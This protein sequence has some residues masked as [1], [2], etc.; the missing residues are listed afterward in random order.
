MRKERWTRETGYGGMNIKLFEWYG[1]E[2]RHIEE[3][4]R[5]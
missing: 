5:K 2:K 3:K 4:I 1:V